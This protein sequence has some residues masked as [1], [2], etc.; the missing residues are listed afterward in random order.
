MKKKPLHRDQIKK[1]KD[2]A[3]RPEDKRAEIDK[4]KKKQ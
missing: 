3:S 1:V 4:K 2:R